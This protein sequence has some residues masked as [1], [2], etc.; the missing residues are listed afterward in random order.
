MKIGYGRSR[1]LWYVVVGAASGGALSI[2]HYY[3]ERYLPQYENF[4]LIAIIPVIVGLLALLAHRENAVFRWGSQLER[5]G[6]KINELMSD[7][8][9]RK[10]WQ[11]VLEEPS[12]PTC[13]RELD[14]DKEDCPVYG[15]ENARCWLIAGTFCRGKVQGKFATKL[16]D[17]RKCEVYLQATGDPVHE[18]TEN[19][20]TMNYLL[21]ER[22]EQLSEAYEEARDRSEKLAGLVGLSEAALSSMHMTEL[23]QHLLQSTASF[24]GADLGIIYLADRNE[25]NLVARVTYG[26]EPGISS[27]LAE[28]VGEGTTGQA[29][30]G[31]YM[32]VSE[33]VAGDSKVTNNYLKSL[34][35]RTLISL[36]LHGR[37][38][39]LGILVLGTLTPHLYTEEEKDSLQVAAD[40]IASAVES[41]Q[42]VNRLGRD[43]GQIKLMAAV[44]SDPGSLDSMT[45]IYDS[46]IKHA[47]GLIDFDRASLDIWHPESGEIEVIAMSTKAARS[48][49]GE[50]IRLPLSALPVDKVIE[51]KKPLVRHEI[52]G[53]EYPADRL[54][55]QEGIKSSVMLPLISKGEV[56]GTVSLGSFNPGAFTREDVELLEPAAWQL[57]L[58][59]DNA[60]L[61]HDA[62]SLSMVDSLTELYNHRC[63]YEVLVRETARSQRYGRP[64]SLI[65]IDI[66][67]FK[68]F[69][70]RYGYIE[71]NNMLKTIARTLRT[72]VREIDIT[73]RYGGDE[74]AV[75]LPEIGIGEGDTGG[76]NA[77]RVADRIRE[78]IAT[79]AFG[80]VA[81]E[82][83]MT[84]SIGV[85]E[86]PTHA[87]DATSLLERAG[88]ALREAKSRGHNRVVTA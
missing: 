4:L 37:E 19:F 61:V 85:A 77:L 71:G 13:W 10:H 86:L 9:A 66:D 64:V 41:G 51:S 84:L 60:R 62:K 38:K 28:V 39:P 18:M 14:C 8:I 21:N 43:R 81:D 5:A 29:F 20:F 12:L 11:P 83:P 69:N 79:R 50:G 88:E 54:L 63:F 6:V 56:I 23:L 2:T 52:T 22:E 31:R 76:M 59:L 82:L 7:A 30:A 55:I 42:L 35:V 75:L 65:M 40:R 73:A 57:G 1:I 49:L 47:Q 80:S 58:I 17:C 78:E 74:F 53:D 68:A 67:G 24:M 16:G 34:G 72:S 3:L 15:R 26:L 27:R 46:F 32:A 36:P 48:W 45:S 70:E 33:D 87:G 44:T 25:E